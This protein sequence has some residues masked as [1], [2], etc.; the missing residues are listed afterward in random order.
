MCKEGLLCQPNKKG[1]FLT[2]LGV[3]LRHFYSPLG[4][5]LSFKLPRKTLSSSVQWITLLCQNINTYVP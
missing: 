4:N 5:L 3:I 2:V 1:D